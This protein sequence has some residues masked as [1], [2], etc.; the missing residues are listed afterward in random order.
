[1]RSSLECR[2][3]R[4]RHGVRDSELF[5]LDYLEVGDD[6]RTLTVYFLGHAPEVVR[7]GNLRVDGGERVHDIEVVDVD[8][9]HSEDPEID[10]WMRVTV[11]RM[12]DFSTYTLKVVEADAY[13][14]PTNRP[15]RDFDRRY[16]AL[17]FSFKIGCPSPLDC[18]EPCAC[19]SP[20]RAVPAVNYLARDYASFRQLI[21][22]RLAL[23][24]PSWTE[25]HAPDVGI[26]LVEL[27]AYVGDYL[28]YEQDA[29]ATEA[30]LATA[31]QRISVRRHA[32][33][34]DYALHEGCNARAWVAIE[35]EGDWA[36]PGDE[37]FFVTA[38][39]PSAHAGPSLSAATL[40]ATAPRDAYL[41]FEPLL[42]QAGAEVRVR[43]A[44][45]TI[46]IYTWGDDS[47]CLAPGATSA[48]LVDAWRDAPANGEPAREPALKA[49][50]GPVPHPERNRALELRAGDWLLFEE[51][52]GPRTGTEADADPTHRHIVCLTSVTQDEDPLTGT[53]IVEVEWCA[54]DALPFPL[55]VSTVGAPPECATIRNISV[56][57][58]NVVLVDHGRRVTRVVGHVE[59][60]E[61]PVE[62]DDCGCAVE[63]VVDGSPFRAPLPDGPLTFA[64]P[65]PDDC[66]SA[67][68]RRREPR[69]ARPALFVCF[70]DSAGDELPEA[71]CDIADRWLP[72]A[73]LL[74]SGGGEAHFAVEVDDRG[75][76]WLRFGDGDLGRAAP[77]GL[78]AV[79]TYRIGNGAAGNVGPESIAHLVYRG[80][81]PGAAVTRVRNPLPATGG[82]EPEP[83][84]TAKLL[85]PGAFHSTLARAITADDYARLAER[86]P[87]VQ[88]AAATRRWTGSWYEAL[89]A[90]DARGAM[91][92]GA[93]LLEDVSRALEPF[94]R[95][96]HDLRVVA[97]HTVPLALSV[98]ACARPDYLRGHI[99]A[100]LRE[101]LGSRALPDGRLGFFHPDNLT[102]GTGVRVSALVA[103]AQ[104]VP[105][106][107][108][109][110]VT[111]LHRLGDRPRREVEEGE[112]RLGPL[113]V[114][115]LDNDPSRP[116][117]GQLTLDVRGGR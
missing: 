17:D 23:L 84:A 11:D 14:A 2:D 34:V 101:A 8:L 70:D 111:A 79:A 106:V 19:P 32:R 20:T 95:V 83:I 46:R 103:A 13:G 76:A 16:A 69:D 56:A 87:R 50:Q 85:A 53:P 81:A 66:C 52:K 22:D 77:T 92:A 88:R 26:A 72:R 82:V 99:V 104:A 18:A 60:E 113:E 24:I 94:R 71:A 5:G 27:L 75:T 41:V 98:R 102:F 38:L 35:S 68:A 80:E 97:A 47:C 100:A 45:G 89:V 15:R 57:R 90:V 44:H 114:A 49:A 28:S 109:V 74:G 36:L 39:P 55:C 58:G 105:G 108:S 21:L 12:G 115:R 112:L 4:R 65:L 29:V 1:M 54:D 7:R 78:R 117:Y 61:E 33:L 96:G 10:D 64:E 73:D 40:E 48:T 43:A 9:H 31:R 107:E 63:A 25:R 116:E 37:I 110:E 42:H 59:V 62:C 3:E 67:A 6:Q 93:G 51:R 30:Y 86:D 91:R